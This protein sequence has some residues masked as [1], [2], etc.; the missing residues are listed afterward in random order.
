MDLYDS[1]RHHHPRLGWV[2]IVR[3]PD[4]Q[5]PYGAQLDN[6]A[7]EPIVAWGVSPAHAIAELEI[8]LS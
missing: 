8:E 2:V 5:H 7:G 3:V 1:K 6:D 4:P